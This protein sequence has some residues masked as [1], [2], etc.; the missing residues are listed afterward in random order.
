M[1]QEPRDGWTK[2]HEE[3]ARAAGFESWAAWCAALEVEYGHELCGGRAGP[4]RRRPCTQRRP[5]DS[6]NGRCHYH[7]RN[8]PRGPAHHAW[9]G[10]NWG[11]WIPKELQVDFEALH[12]LVAMFDELAALRAEFR[13]LF[14]RLHR[15]G[16]EPAWRVARS[17]W[18][19]VQSAVSR[20]DAE[21]LA[22]A[23]A[24]LEDALNEGLAEERTRRQVLQVIEQAR[25]VYETEAKRQEAAQQFMHRAQVIQLMRQRAEADA[26][27]IRAHVSD[28]KE[29]AALQRAMADKA[30]SEMQGDGL[31]GIT[32]I[33]QA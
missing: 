31:A 26:A 8:A 9:T 23:E 28:R 22:R 16:G 6:A 33:G 30:I 25:K 20:A 19:R 3:L 17:A 14:R 15:E 2:A 7:K 13:A 1:A 18:R 21:A 27:L 5:A 4:E 24:E 10:K 29:R 12:G 32:P 11:E